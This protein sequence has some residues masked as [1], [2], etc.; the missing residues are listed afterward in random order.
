MEHSVICKG[1]LDIFTITPSILRSAGLETGPILSPMGRGILGE[2][3]SPPREREAGRELN[4]LF[5][6]KKALLSRQSEQCF[7]F[8]PSMAKPSLSGDF[9]NQR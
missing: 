1:G 4:T 7:S 5:L 6:N 3:L 2:T 8:F 9:K